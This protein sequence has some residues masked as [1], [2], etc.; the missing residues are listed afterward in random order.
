MK[1]VNCNKKAWQSVWIL[2]VLY[3]IVKMPFMSLNSRHTQRN[4]AASG[5]RA[6]VLFD[7]SWW[8][9]ATDRDKSSQSVTHTEI[10]LVNAYSYSLTMY[11]AIADKTLLLFAQFPTTLCEILKNSDKVRYCQ[12][13][14]TTVLHLIMNKDELTKIYRQILTTYFHLCRRYNSMMKGV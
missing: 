6:F 13:L 9:E 11:S 3:Y 10:S 14:N 4:Q 5:K 2:R 12:L 7:P 8:K 1:F